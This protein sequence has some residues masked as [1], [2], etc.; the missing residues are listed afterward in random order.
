MA[1]AAARYR[2]SHGRLVK[3]RLCGKTTFATSEAKVIEHIMGP[4][5]V[6]DG[7]QASTARIFPNALRFVG[8]VGRAFHQRFLMIVAPSV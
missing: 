1:E 2:L 3:L 8:F 7:G 4:G 5:R 6:G